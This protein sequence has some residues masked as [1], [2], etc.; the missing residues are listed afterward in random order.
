MA[1]LFRKLFGG[2]PIPPPTHINLAVSVSSTTL[3]KPGSN[4]DF[5]LTLEATLPDTPSTPDKPLTILVFDSL[6]GPGGNTLYENGLDFI[7]IDTGVPAKRTA[8]IFEYSF[9]GRSDIPV[10]P[11][12]EYYFVT[13]HPGVPHR[14]TRTL[15]PCPRVRRDKA[16]KPK[17]VENS[18]GER[19]VTAEDEDIVASILSHV[20][21]MEVGSTYRVELGNKMNKIW[22]YRYGT[23]EEVLGEQGAGGCPAKRR[24]ELVGDC[25]MEPIPLIL[26][27]SASFTV[28]E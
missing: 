21:N 3:H 4:T 17:Q 26:Q 16:D 25:E 8:M 12:Y 23:K 20:T 6:L 18:L 15:R 13:L 24:R 10:E 5:Q 14:V 1:Y 22:W 11:Q 2:S 19:V 28:V 9:G 7:D 27:D